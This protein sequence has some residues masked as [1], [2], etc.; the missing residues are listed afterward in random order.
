MNCH[1]V[2]KGNTIHIKNGAINKIFEQ[3]RTL[4]PL[5]TDRGR[6]I[7]V[8]VNKDTQVEAHSNKTF[9]CPHTCF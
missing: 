8:P 9:L 1:D 6:V 7:S 2:S 4:P 5:S 3:G